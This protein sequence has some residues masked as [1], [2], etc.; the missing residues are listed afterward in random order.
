M[1]GADFRLNDRDVVR[2][3]PRKNEMI[4]VSG[5][6]RSPG[7]FELPKE[8][9]IHMLDA[10][11]M[12]GGRSS[13]VADKVLVIRRVENRPQPLVIQASLAKAKQNGLENLRLTAGDTIT[14]EQTPVTTVVDAVGKFFRLSFGIASNTVF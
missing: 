10:I 8:Q 1:Q 7:Q 14:I 3:V 2:V 12:A 5:L 9:D 13:P 6:V 11:A 4:H